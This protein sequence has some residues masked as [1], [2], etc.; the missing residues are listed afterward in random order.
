MTKIKSGG[1]IWGAV[2]LTILA[3]CGTPPAPYKEPEAGLPSAELRDAMDYYKG[4]NSFSTISMKEVTDC[5]KGGAEVAVPSYQLFRDSLSSKVDLEKFLKIQP[6]R[7]LQFS[8]DYRGLSGTCKVDIVVILQDG[9]KYELVGF[10]NESNCQLGMRD[11]GT[12]ANVLAFKPELF[13][14]KTK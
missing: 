5:S 13:A 12:G 4:R 14:C 3:G 1:C 11:M 6:N 9:H 7:P 8:L 2:L 10:T